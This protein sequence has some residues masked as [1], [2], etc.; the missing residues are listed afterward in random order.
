MGS[1]EI[2]YGQCRELGYPYEKMSPS[3][4]QL[5]DREKISWDKYPIQKMKTLAEYVINN[6]HGLFY[7]LQNSHWHSILEEHVQSGKIAICSKADVFRHLLDR[8]KFVFL[9]LGEFN[10][11]IGRELQSM[12]WTQPPG[13]LSPQHLNALD[14]HFD[15]LT[16]MAKHIDDA[17]SETGKKYI[18]LC[19]QTPEGRLLGDMLYLLA[20]SVEG[21]F[22]L[23]CESIAGGKGRFSLLSSDNMC[24][25]D[26]AHY[27]VLIYNGD[28]IGT[29]RFNF[30]QTNRATF[31]GNKDIE[32]HFIC[33]EARQCKSRP[34]AYQPIIFWGNPGAGTQRMRIV[35]TAMMNYY[36]ISFSM[37]GENQP[38]WSDNF[39]TCIQQ[40]FFNETPLGKT[41]SVIKM[42]EIMPHSSCLYVHSTGYDWVKIATSTNARLII[43][44]RDIRDQYISRAVAWYWAAIRY[45]NKDVGEVIRAGELLK[46]YS[47]QAEMLVKAKDC[48][49]ITFIRF[50]DIDKDPIGTYKDLFLKLFPDDPAYVEKSF[51]DTLSYSVNQSLP[52]NVLRYKFHDQCGELYGLSPVLSGK[53][54]KWQEYF[55][56]TL[57]NYF[58]SNM[59]DYLKVFGYENDDNW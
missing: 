33:G 30:F 24:S 23:P 11:G 49:N 51:L 16:R 21:V 9:D 52:G 36:G 18:Y 47:M 29:G 40:R 26:P 34:L 25:L 19:K 3:L 7:T 6:V 37:E 2:Y 55:D 31:V 17:A 12:M 4:H 44:I 20:D 32:Y 35:W 46:K 41:E 1:Y 53:P 10:G 15:Y 5:F 58:K 50:E 45:Q 56:E 28:G 43:L 54:G 38:I 59:H 42:Y 8:R 57:K 48:P 14:G 39:A 13:I 22:K 27:A